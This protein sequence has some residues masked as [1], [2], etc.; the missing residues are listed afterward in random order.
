MTM[1]GFV[2]VPSTRSLRLRRARVPATLVDSTFVSPMPPDAE[3]LLEVDI[4]VADGRIAAVAP[5]DSFPS[6]GSIDLYRSQVWPAFV[7]IHTHLDISHTWLRSP[8]PDG[9]VAGAQRA[10]EVDRN[11]RWPERDV[12]RRMDFGLRCAYAHGVV[13]IRTHLNSNRIQYRNAWSAFRQMRDQWAG[14]IDLQ[15][16][17]LL[18]LPELVGDFGT[19]IADLVAEAGGNLG[20]AISM[21]AEEH[22]RI[23]DRF[24]GW[25]NHMFSLAEERGLD[26]DLH[27]DENGDAG[28]RGLHAVA[29]TALRR[30]FKGRILCGHCCSLAVQPDD[31]IEATLAACASAGIAVVSLPMCNMYLQDRSSRRTPRWRGITLLHEMRERGIA[32][33]LGT[34]DVRN[35]WYGFGDQDMVEVFTQGVRIAHL[36]RP[37][38]DWPRAVTA[39]PARVMRLADRGIIRVRA[40]ADLVLFNARDM[41]ELLSRPQ[42][43]RVVLRG[44]RPITRDLPSYRELDDLQTPVATP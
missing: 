22:A 43:D 24:A 20:V 26:L 10:A 8:N 3:G 36:D 38:D 2:P 28:A 18:Q 13:A 30:G 4:E 37:Y 31:M 42:S 35:A 33:S 12:I 9:T 39:T 29:R 21:T 15:A 41:S 1:S 14:Q 6:E 23:A 11:T 19:E 17:S 27:V 16:T 40:P 5:A 7:D 25:L 34:D 32:V 44:G